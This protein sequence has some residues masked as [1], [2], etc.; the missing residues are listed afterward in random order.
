M[1]VA[2]QPDIVMVDKQQMKAVVID[3]PIPSDSNIRRKEQEKF[4]IYQGLKAELE[5]MWGVK[6]S[7]VLV[8]KGALGTVIPKLA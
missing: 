7:V 8:V 3:V 2:N 5:R 6:P 1:V 4:E